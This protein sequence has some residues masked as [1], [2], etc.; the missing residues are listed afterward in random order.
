MHYMLGPEINKVELTMI[1][2][3]IC[4]FE[5]VFSF[6]S[7]V[8]GSHFIELSIKEKQRE[9]KSCHLFLFVQCV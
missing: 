7:R 4:L 1:P 2:F 5:S 9:Y 8:G 3:L 6:F